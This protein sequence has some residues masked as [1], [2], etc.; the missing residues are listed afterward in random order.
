MAKNL[1]TRPFSNF[2]SATMRDPHRLAAALLGLEPLVGHPLLRTRVGRRFRLDEIEAA[3][4]FESTPGAK[5]VL[6]P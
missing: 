1:T 5:A 3:M 2:A 6:Q 4:A